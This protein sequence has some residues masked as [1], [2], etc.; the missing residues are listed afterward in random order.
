[1]TRYNEEAFNR[2]AERYEQRWK[3]YLRH[4]HRIFLD[5]ITTEENDI[6]LDASSGTGLLAEEMLDSGM[7][8]KKLVLNDPSGGML[9]FARNRLEEHSQITYSN[10]TVENLDL[11][12]QYFDRIFCLNA[13]HFYSDQHKVLENFNRVLKPGGRLYVLDW[14]RAGFFRLV[15]IIIKWSTTEN[16]NTLS[17]VEM[18]KMLSEYGFHVIKQ[19]EWNHRYWKFFFIESRK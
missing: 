1:M 12:Q 10:N 19:A 13:F 2:K 15:N 11:N 17:L 7:P 6:L 16:I 9:D 14:N 18:T 5:H 8:F 3:N 4:T